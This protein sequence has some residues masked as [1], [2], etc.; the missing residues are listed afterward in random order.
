[1]EENGGL[2]LKIDAKG[3]EQIVPLRIHRMCEVIHVIDDA[4]LEAYA[5]GQEAMIPLV[6]VIP[7]HRVQVHNMHFCVIHGWTVKVA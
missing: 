6:H 7:A 3:M 2:G 4:L 5:I 1:L